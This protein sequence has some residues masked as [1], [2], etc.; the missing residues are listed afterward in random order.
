MSESQ[1]TIHEPDAAP[2]AP[3]TRPRIAT[4]PDEIDRRAANMRIA[5]HLNSMAIAKAHGMSPEWTETD[6]ERLLL[7]VEMTDEIATGANEGETVP[8]GFGPAVR[9]RQ[10]EAMLRVVAKLPRTADAPGFA[11]VAGGPSAGA[12]EGGG[13]G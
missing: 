3:P 5:S 4:V 6:V 9:A 12:A 8:Q 7:M 1:G 11:G 2:D 13:N 10:T